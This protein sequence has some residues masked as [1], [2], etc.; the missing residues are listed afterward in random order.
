MQESVSTYYD[1]ELDK[2]IENINKDKC[3]LVLLQFPDGLKYYSKEVVDTLREKTQAEYLRLPPGSY[4]FSVRAIEL[5]GA[6][7]ETSQVEITIQKPWYQSPGAYILY[8]LMFASLGITIRLY[9]SRK[10][11]QEHGK[12]MDK[13]HT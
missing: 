7:T 2:L 13:R 4:T 9:L 8:L 6:L 10:R 11:W 1:L 12:F 5:N 3:K